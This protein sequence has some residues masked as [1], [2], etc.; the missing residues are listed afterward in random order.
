[1]DANAIQAAYGINSAPEVLSI[2]HSLA[3]KTTI[4]KRSIKMR[5]SATSG[6]CAVK[7]TGDQRKLSAIC[8][9][10]SPIDNRLVGACHVR[11]PTIAT[12]K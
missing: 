5:A 8:A 10:H 7:N 3:M 6:R 11:Q 4:E 12:I 9:H 1:M 2:D